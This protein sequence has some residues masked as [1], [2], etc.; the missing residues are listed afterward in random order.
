[1]KNTILL[2]EDNET[3]G[4]ILQEYLEMNVMKVI[5]AKTGKEGLSYFQKN[6]IDLCILDI[7]MP[8]MDGFSLAEKIKA[9]NPKMPLIF[10]TAK[11]LKI[12]KLKGFKLGAD[13]YIIKPVDE[14]ELVARIQAVL[15]R[16]HNVIIKKEETTFHIGKYLFHYEKQLLEIGEEQISIS[17]KEAEL[18]KL[19]CEHKNEV[20]SRNE[21]LKKLW[22]ISDYFNRRSMDVFISK[23]RKYLSKDSSVSIDNIHSKG[24]ILKA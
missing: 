13:D 4:Y 16:S 10:L 21:T 11:S 22:G 14:E 1:M 15:N 12:D 7:M 20:L 19:L 8:E 18:L 6:K 24:F 5:R 9:S 3:L 23:L 2:V 17:K